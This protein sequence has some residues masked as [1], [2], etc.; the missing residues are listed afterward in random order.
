LKR[1]PFD[2]FCAII[3][4]A[5]LFS[6]CV[7][8]IKDR[9]DF[10]LTGVEPPPYPQP[11]YGINRIGTPG[12]TTGMVVALKAQ[13]VGSDYVQVYLSAKALTQGKSA[14]KL[15]DP[16]LKDPFGRTPN[17]PPLVN[18]LYIPFS[19]IYY[20]VGLL[21]H[22]FMTLGIFIILSLLVIFQTGYLRFSWKVLIIYLLLYF[23]TPLGYSHYEK[24]QFD[25]YTAGAHLLPAVI[26]MG[27]AG[28]LFFLTGFLAAFKWSSLP[29][30][31]AFSALAFLAS[32]SKKRWYFVIPLVVVIL[33]VLLFWQQFLE[34][35]PS[36]QT[37]EVNFDHPVGL[38]FWHLMPK[39]L[40]KVFQIICLVLFGGFFLFL[41]KKENR[42]KLFEM[43]SLPFA[44]A[45][46]A[47]GLCFGSISLEYR[48]VTLLGMIVPLLLWLQRAEVDEKIKLSIAITFGAFLLI[49]F[50]NF[51]YL[52]RLTD[53][54]LT[55]IFLIA[56]LLWL[57]TACYII[58]MNRSQTARLAIQN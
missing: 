13:P 47:Q 1:N 25:F 48:V 31:G 35:L 2:I 58:L 24:G 49:A 43:I 54:Q 51:Q 15:T 52:I 41:S 4:I 55:T 16:N 14:Y 57:G 12:L 40:A 46:T 7:N 20:P 53:V 29:F 5:I 17:Y 44:L 22:N 34:Y 28:W 19:R 30:L 32:E 23:Y 27:N 26:F 11:Y 39:A 21:I 33:S 10:I 3:V 45:M 56:S 36:F 8:D 9:V 6:V 38:S 50:R 37:Y 18:W 42:Q